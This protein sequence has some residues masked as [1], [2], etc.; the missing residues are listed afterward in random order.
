MSDVFISFASR[1]GKRVARIHAHLIDR[2]YDV[3]WMRNL[4]P[5]D[6]PIRTVSRELVDARYV[7]LAWSRSAEESPYVEG[8]I[9]HAF[10]ARKLLPVRIEKWHWPAFLS[11]VQYVDMTP[12]DD[13]AEAWQRLEERLQSDSDQ[14]SF[15]LP[16]PAPIALPRSAGPV[17][18]LALTML[19]LMG[20]LVW[21]LGQA[22]RALLDGDME[23]LRLAQA[24][25]QFLP[26]FAAI[27]V[28]VA[29]RRVWRAWRSRP[30]RFR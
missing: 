9:M 21:M 26:A 23:A 20:L 7:L 13:E 29:T 4:R 14:H 15:V 3:W 10:G 2:G 19:V 5:G 25:V 18:K 12:E 24:V 1:D 17:G 27:P 8:E 28:V 11:S 30:D 22:Y 6:S 16:A